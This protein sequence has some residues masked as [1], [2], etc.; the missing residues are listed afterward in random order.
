M[1]SWS[2]CLLRS[3]TDLLGP[4]QSARPAASYTI[5]WDSIEI[6]RVVQPVAI[7]A[8]R[9]AERMLTMASEERRRA[10][11]LDLQK[12]QYE[13]GLAERRYAA[14]DPENR[15][16]AATLERNWEAT[17]QRLEACKMRVDVGEAPIVAVEPPDLE[18]LA[19]EVATAWNA[20]GVSARTRQRLVR[21]LIKDI[22]ADVDGK[23][24]VVAAF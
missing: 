13:A 9:E 19:E 11:E 10:A 5:S 3:A 1:M 20:A 17:L 14:C 21:T 8:A 23:H 22:V 16:I 18:G 4:H 2:A 15:L 7:E 6:L 12:A 24:P